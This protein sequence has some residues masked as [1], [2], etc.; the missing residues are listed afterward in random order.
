MP[1]DAHLHLRESAIVGTAIS[2]AP[3]T[4]RLDKLRAVSIANWGLHAHFCWA[5][6]VSAAFVAGGCAAW[7]KVVKAWQSATEDGTCS[8]HCGIICAGT[9]MCVR[10]YCLHCMQAAQATC[11]G[12]QQTP[13]LGQWTPVHMPCMHKLTPTLLTSEAQSRVEF[14]VHLPYG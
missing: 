14:V 3:A 10:R 1:C 13:S 11:N 9:C 4:R 5:V 6:S 2:I 12:V 8:C 7:V